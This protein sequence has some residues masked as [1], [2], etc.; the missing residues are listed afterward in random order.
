M[1]RVI[2]LHNAINSEKQRTPLID[3]R[4]DARHLPLAKVEGDLGLSR[5][6]A[7]RLLPSVLKAWESIEGNEEL[8]SEAKLLAGRR[9]SVGHRD[10]LS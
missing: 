5:N 4:I 10:T 6:E 2:S 3:P 9:E 8:V 1:P 7:R